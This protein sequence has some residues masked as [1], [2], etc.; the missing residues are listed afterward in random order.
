MV[1]IIAFLAALICAVL[2]ERFSPSIRKSLLITLCVYVILVLGLRYR[3]GV[4]TLNYMNTYRFIP[5]LDQFFYNN[6]AKMIRYEPGFLFVC[7]LCKTL[8]GDFWTVQIIMA[9]LT[10]SCI[11]YFIYR[12]CKNPFVGIV[13]YFILQCLYFNTEIMR[14]SA[15][16]AIFLLNFKNLQEKK[17]LNYYLLACLSLMFHYSAIVIFFFPFASWLKPNYI[18]LVLCICFL[19]ITP[20]VEQLNQLLNIAAVS[21]RVEQYIDGAEDLNLNWRIGELIRSALPAFA[22]IIAYK[23]SKQESP[24]QHML[25]LQ[26]LFCMGAFAIPIIFSRFTNYTTLFVTVGAANVL[27]LRGAGMWIKSG[28]VAVIIVSQSYYYYAMKDR[29]FPYCSIFYPENNRERNQVYR[30]DFL[31]WLKNM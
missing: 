31:P 28:I 18:F 13:F 27:T 20:L 21:G 4:D 16:V 1:Y 5:T 23:L 12:S 17:W 7:C 19:A 22:V 3:V 30:H 25:L 24:F 2:N 6:T 14:E 9:A 11:F 15:A 10:N 26:I 29:W 8:Y